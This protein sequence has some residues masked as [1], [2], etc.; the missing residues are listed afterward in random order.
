MATSN[1]ELASKLN[2]AGAQLVPSG[3]RNDIAAWYQTNKRTLLSM[4]GGDEQRA[5]LFIS[6]A[7]S[8]INKIPELM[9]C[10]RNSLYQCIVY[11]M[12]MNLLPGPMA[13]CYYLPFKNKRTGKKEATFVPSYFGLVKLAYNSGFVTKIHGHVV[14]ERDEF[15][16]D[17]VEDRPV[18]RK[19]KGAHADRGKR[20]HVY[21][22]IKNIYRETQFMV[23]DAESVENI[24]KRSP[25]ASSKAS[26]W[27]SE[28]DSDVEAMWLKTCF[29]R[30]VKWIVKESKSNPLA[31]G[32]A[33][34]IDDK[35]EVGE[36]QSSIVMD[37]GVQSVIDDVIK[38]EPK[39]KEIEQ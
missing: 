38:P 23:M 3:F 2:N 16:Y 14:Y 6:A 26:P 7:F 24:K 19:F 32:K 20:T 18:H 11:S 8:Q 34:E 22:A 25:A 37:D 39:P 13:E 12:G 9:N 35:S 1:A 17:P 15:D 21:T 29:R 36:I 4:T 27:N 31:L 5:A 10:D 28:H 30:G 33:L